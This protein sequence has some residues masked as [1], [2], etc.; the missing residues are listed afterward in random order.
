MSSY[1]GLSEFEHLNDFT[2]D[3]VEESADD[4]SQLCFRECPA[5]DDVSAEKSRP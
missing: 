4:V 1:F 5:K 3:T 2:T